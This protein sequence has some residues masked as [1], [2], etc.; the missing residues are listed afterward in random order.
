VPLI[1]SDGTYRVFQSGDGLL[2]VS[3]LALLA[4]A[5]DGSQGNLRSRIGRNSMLPPYDGKLAFGAWHY[6]ATLDRLDA[7]ANST[8]RGTSGAY[9][10]GDRIVARD[11][12][13]TN[14]NLSLF[15]Q[16][17]VADDRVNRFGTYFG[18]GMVAAGPFRARPNDEMGFA[19]AIARNGSGYQNRQASL[20]P[21]SRAETALEL[22]YLIQATSWLAVQPDLQYVI[23]PNT[24][25]TIP[26]ALVFTLRFELAKQ[27]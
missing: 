9:L 22:S 15:A 7:G 14:R 27:F 25:P 13:N 8:Q 19:V 24:D 4:R 21:T 12:A 2:A 5:A 10:V 6:T 3:E 20:A 1:R 26:K 23:H 18:A 11:P 16:F 17:G